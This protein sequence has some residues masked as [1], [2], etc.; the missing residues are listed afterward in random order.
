MASK[1]TLPLLGQTMEEGTVTKW[2]KKEGDKVAKDETLLE[3]MTDK[4]NMEVESPESGTLLKI[5]VKEDETVPVKALIAILGEPGEDISGILAEAEAAGGAA[6]A[7]PAEAPAAAA[8]PA[9]PEAASVPAGRLLASPR[10]RKVADEKG[11]DINLLAGEGSGPG[12]RIIEKDVLAAIEAAP[13]A[14]PLARKMAAEAGVDL[15]G[16]SGTGPGGKI[17]SE[18]VVSP[19]GAAAAAPAA[20][21]ALAPRV[22][23]GKVIP[24]SGLRK[25]VADN[26]S[27]SAATV[28][29][30]TLTTSVDMTE[31]MKLRAQVKPVYEKRY[32][33]KLGYTDIIVKAAAKAVEDY[34]IM[35]SSLIGAEIRVHD[36][37]DISVAIAVEGGLLAP[38]VHDTN[39]KPLWAI[40]GE[41]RDMAG[42]AREGKLKP[43]EMT[44]GT[45]TVTSL[46]NWGVE[47]FTPVINPPQVAILGV[48]AIKPQ[49]V[50]VDGQVQVRSMMNLCLTFDHR[51]V[52][53]APAAEFLAHLKEMLENP[54]LMLA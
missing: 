8:A 4:A 3:V 41:I 7:A 1:V 5:V 40:S 44:G 10:A 33:V 48:C 46:G 35:N 53:G 6:P 28:V 12:G 31:A 32:G 22:P 21:P 24:F 29:P 49:P 15:A 43:S 14:T 47:Q 13:A 30:V 37:V 51:V 26:L 39:L 34:P 54:Y 9:A 2:F 45:F 27:K 20:A 36:S 17:R 11:F 19:A 16:V 50:V 42:R 18:D 25:A 52:D 23:L 38:P